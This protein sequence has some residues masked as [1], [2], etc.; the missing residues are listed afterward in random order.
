MR[1]CEG[2][3]DSRVEEVG[4]SSEE[5]PGDWSSLVEALMKVGG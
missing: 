1:T 3:W 5:E 2:Y 4:F